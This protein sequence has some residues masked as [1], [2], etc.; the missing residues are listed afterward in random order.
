MRFI[1]LLLLFGGVIIGHAQSILIQDQQRGRP[2][3]TALIVGPGNFSVSTG[4]DGLA[5]LANFSDEDTI[6][7]SHADYQTLALSYE[8]LRIKEFRVILL[9]KTKA[10]PEVLVYADHWSEKKQTQPQRVEK[11]NPKEIAFQNSQTTADLLGSSGGVFVQ[12]SQL[13]GG[14]PILRGMATNRVLLVVDGVRMNNAIFRAGN[15]QAVISLDAN[16]MQGA[17]IIFGPGAVI[18]GSDAIGGVMNFQTLEPSFADSSRKKPILA[19]LLLR[20]SS[21]NSEKTKHLDLSLSFRKWGFVSS[22]SHS[23]YGDLRSGRRGGVN[24]FY[25]PSYVETID[26]RDYMR[27][28]TDS[29][30]QVGSAYSQL[31]ILQKISFAASAHTTLDYGFQWSQ[32]SSYN[33]YDRLTVMQTSG[34]YKNQ[35]RWAEWYYGPQKWN[36]HRLSATFSKKTALYDQLKWIVAMQN[37]EESRYDREFMVHE[38]RMQKEKVRALSFNLDLNKSIGEHTT[39]AYGAEFVNNLVRSSATLSHVISHSLSPTV[40][41]YPDRSTW[42][43]YGLY[44]TL[45]RSLTKKIELNAGLR[46]SYYE[47]DADFDTSFFPFPFNQAQLQTRALN[48]SIGWIYSPIKSLQFYTNLASGF[49]APNIDD[50]GKVFESTPGY[51]VVPNPNLKPEHGY[52]LEAGFATTFARFVRLDGAAYYTVINDAMERKDFLLN[53][54]SSIQ[55]LGNNSRIQ[56]IQN[57]TKIMVLGGQAG[58]EIK[59]RKFTLKSTFSIQRGR[60]QTSDSLVY[61]PLRH[62]APAFGQTQ[63]RYQTKKLRLEFYSV[64]NGAMP[65]ERLA[66]TERINLSYARD[67]S[68]DPKGRAYSAAW[69]TL[70]FKVAYYFKNYLELDAG[71]E[72]IGAVL[73]RPYSSGINAPGRNYLLALRAHF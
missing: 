65:Y 28:N 22:V 54:Q 2:L 47:I 8:D 73:Y 7:I 53:G 43:S 69:Y 27:T 34:P 72:N 57:V 39:L 55:F 29:S 32:T 61:Y 63:I 6:R 49:R 16:A 36:M 56:A 70:N 31:N 12:K 62:A 44:L 10:L 1:C 15:L 11:I 71:V 13:G 17:E 24:S 68:E 23:D 19:N 58:I 50:I 45:R 67:Y 66:P 33:R 35:L 25:R 20:G 4:K 40:T 51:L 46:Y 14:S 37:F 18:Y 52:N 21:A 9:K 38:L 30:L 60:E 26:N 3:A 59:W 42:D 5:R 64:Y 41:R 48:G